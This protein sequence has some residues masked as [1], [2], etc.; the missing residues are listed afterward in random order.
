MDQNEQKSGIDLSQIEANVPDSM[1]PVLEFLVNN[2]KL[3]ALG[4]GGLVVLALAVGGYQWYEGQ[5]IAAAKA[6]LGQ[7][8]TSSTGDARLEKL[9]GFLASAPEG[10][11]RGVLLELASTADAQ[12]KHDQAARYWNQLAGLADADMRVIAR[13][14]MAKSLLEADKAKE[15]LTQMQQLQAEAPAAYTTSILR[16]LAVT[17]EAAGDLPVA[18]EAY[19]K[20]AEKGDALNKQFVEF[21][22]GRLEANI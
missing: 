2:V 21:K 1:H 10:M 8:L 9:E 17:A 6:E 18:L 3:L 16:Q 13:L 14:G 11:K 12:D 15:A 20:L 4:A 7:I 5:Q 22:I 19:R